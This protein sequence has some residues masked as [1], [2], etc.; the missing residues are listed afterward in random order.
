LLLEK[1]RNM[2]DRE[3]LRLM[4]KNIFDSEHMEK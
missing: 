1:R 4:S 2:Q 3:F